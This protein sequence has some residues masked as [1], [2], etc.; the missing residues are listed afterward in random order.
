MGTGTCGFWAVEGSAVAFGGC[1]GT[2][3]PEK[4]GEFGG[5]FS[6]RIQRQSCPH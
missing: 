6:L 2:F 3:F 1:W 5:N 4:G